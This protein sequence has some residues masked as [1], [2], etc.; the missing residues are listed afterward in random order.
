[1]KEA[2]AQAARL[3]P[4][5]LGKDEMNLAEYPLSILTHR[6]PR[7]RKTYSFT[8]RITDHEGTVIKQSWSVLGSDK[9]GLGLALV[10]QIAR[11][12]GG[13]ARCLPRVG[14]GTC[15]EVDLRT[16]Q[17]EGRCVGGARGTAP[18]DARDRPGAHRGAGGVPRTARRT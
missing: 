8:Q 6:V 10:R 2:E 12:H 3:P 7:H 16:G 9:Y 17:P 15:F 4:I 14:G 1:M 18:P 5:I 13:K 11:H